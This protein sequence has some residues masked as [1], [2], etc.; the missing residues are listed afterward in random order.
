MTPAPDAVVP[1]YM[2]AQAAGLMDALL[3]QGAGD[4]DHAALVTVYEQLAGVEEV[5]EVPS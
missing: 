2:T 3:A 4:L 1:K 5:V